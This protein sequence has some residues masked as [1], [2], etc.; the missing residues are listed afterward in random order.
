MPARSAHP[1]PAR[2]L[3]RLLA[4]CGFVVALAGCPARPDADAR[5]AVAAN[6]TGVARE[7]A[8]D[9]AQESGHT[10]R[11]SSG[12]T[13]MLQA[14]VRNGAPFDLL[15]AAD[16]ATPRQLV[17]DHLADGASLHDYAIGR[18][19]L[20]APDR[21]LS[22]DGEKMLRHESLERMAIANPALAPYGVGARETLQH[23]GRWDALQAR[24]LV[25]ENA[26]QATQFVA[27]GASPQGLLPRSLV[28]ELVRQGKEGTPWLVPAEWHAPI[29]QTAVLLH[30]GRGNTAAIGFLRYLRG[31]RARARIREA[32]YDSP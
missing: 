11:I 18:L 12:S 28:L 25:G 32:G 8:A 6:F 21:D 31:E 15:L 7:L 2:A 5:V 22:S 9:Y 23:V 3:L 19:V 1:V 4:S 20:W 14:Q 10:I 29:V 30:H 27:S 26:S 17:S 13:G 24:L 16:A